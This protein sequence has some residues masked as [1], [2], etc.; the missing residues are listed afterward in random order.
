MQT[1]AHMKFPKN[2]T[3]HSTI[4]NN[5]WCQ[6]TTTGAG[7]THHTNTTLFYVPLP[8]EQISVEAT[9]LNLEIAV[10]E[11]PVEIPKYIM[12][13]KARVDPKAFSINLDDDCSSL[14]YESFVKDIA[15]SMA[16]G[17]PSY[18]VPLP[19]SNFST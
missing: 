16:N 15:W 17:L 1:S 19:L 6:E 13:K 10:E 18:D 4:D 11:C 2:I 7:T 5:D 9:S 3:L 12:P 14:L 8:D